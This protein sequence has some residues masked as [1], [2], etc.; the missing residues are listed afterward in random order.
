MPEKLCGLKQKVLVS[1][2]WSVFR[3][4]L[5]IIEITL[6]FMLYYTYFSSFLSWFTLPDDLKMTS[7]AKGD[8]SKWLG[9]LNLPKLSD[10]A[11]EA[12]NSDITTQEILDAI[13]S[14][15]SGKAAGPDGFGIELYKNF[16]GKV[17]PILLR[18]FTHSF[19]IPP[20][21]IYEA[22]ISLLLKEGR[23]ETDPSSFCPFTLLN[24]DMKIHFKKLFRKQVKWLHFIHYSHWSNWLCA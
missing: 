20:C 17:A 21:T 14:F 5:S 22:N 19:E 13:K 9:C 24:S 2:T 1:I 16:S 4:L 12:L 23:E 3:G 10:A 7:K 18:M 15:P 11:W 8:V 6:S